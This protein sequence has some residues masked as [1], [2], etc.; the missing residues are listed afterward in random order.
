MSLAAVAVVASGSMRGCT[1]IGGDVILALIFP[2]GTQEI[3]LCLQIKGW[4]GPGEGAFLPLVLICVSHV[5]DGKPQ[6]GSRT[7][8]SPWWHTEM[9]GT[10]VFLVLPGTWL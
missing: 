7:V 5:K 1:C 6:M 4:K 3:C 2:H 9:V 8:C 10:D